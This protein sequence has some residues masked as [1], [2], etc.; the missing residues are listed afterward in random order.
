MES[1][2]RAARVADTLNYPLNRPPKVRAPSWGAAPHTEPP[3]ARRV[4][5]S[6]L[7][8]VGQGQGSGGASGM[9]LVYICANSG[10]YVKSEMQ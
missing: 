7:R 9:E 4:L 5:F 2:S 6:S 3:H 10:N 8:L 1:V